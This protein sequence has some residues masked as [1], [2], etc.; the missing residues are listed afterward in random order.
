MSQTRNDIRVLCRDYDFALTDLRKQKH[1]ILGHNI[2]THSSVLFTMVACMLLTRLFRLLSRRMS[3][4]EGLIVQCH[5]R[6]CMFL[7]I[8]VQSESCLILASHVQNATTP[9]P[10]PSRLR[11]ILRMSTQMERRQNLRRV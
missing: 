2:F 6:P 7:F 5:G 11:N 10:P 1:Q 3:M 8:I 4:S 9:F